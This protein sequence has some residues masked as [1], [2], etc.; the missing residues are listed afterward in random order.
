MAVTAAAA[1]AAVARAVTVAMISSSG[2]RQHKLYTRDTDVCT[3][4]LSLSS[5]TYQVMQ[6]FTSDL[7]CFTWLRKWLYLC[8]FNAM[9]RKLRPFCAAHLF[10][11]FVTLYT[12][13]TSLYDKKP[14][15]LFTLSSSAIHTQVYLLALQQLLFA[16]LLVVLVEAYS[17]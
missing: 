5:T 7:R 17:Y 4:S 3:W 6:S 1:V 10:A 15:D 11:D 14:C 8:V 12:A 13:S 16:A 9:F 2:S